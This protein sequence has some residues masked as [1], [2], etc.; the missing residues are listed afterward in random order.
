MK[1][2]FV[3]TIAIFVL[4]SFTIQN[5]SFAQDSTFAFKLNGHKYNQQEDLM[6]RA[7]EEWFLVAMD[8]LD[9]PGLIDSMAAANDLIINELNE[10]ELVDVFYEIDESETYDFLSNITLDTLYISATGLGCEFEVDIIGAGFVIGGVSTYVNGEFKI[11]LGE[12]VILDP[13]ISVVGTGHI[14]CPVL[15]DTFK[16]AIGSEIDSLLLGLASMY[17]SESFDN[18]LTF[19]NPIQ[20]LGIEDSVLIE[21]AL[22]SFPMN[23]DMY[24]EKDDD[25]EIVQL[26]IEIN[27]LLGTTSNPSAFIGIEPSEIPGSQLKTGGFSFLYWVL[28]NSFLWHDWT[29]SQRV[30]AAFGIMDDVDI[31]GYRLELRWSDLQ[32]LAYLGYELDPADITPDKI[33]SILTESEHWDTTAF[34]AIQEYLNNGITRELGPFMAVG[35]GHQDRM[36][37]DGSGLG[38]APATEEWEAAEGYT[39]VSASEYLYNLKIYAHATVRKFADEIEVWQ[40]EN[41]LNAAGFAAAVPELWRKGDLWLD[42]EFR[43]QVWAVLVDAV[44]TEDPDPTTMII[45]DLH[46]LGFMQGLEVWVEDM[47]IVGINYYPNLVASLP[48]MGFTVGEYVWAV[49]RA[50]NGLGHEEKPVWLTET[51]YP[52]IEIAD[53]PDNINLADD[54]V[55]FSENRQNEYVETALK[56]AVDNGVSGFFYYSL[57]TQEDR[58]GGITIPMRF[59]GMVRRD[60]D[61]YKPALQTFA[62]LYE[63]LLIIDPTAINDEILIFPEKASLHQNY[64][65]PF[66][67]KTVISYQL[68][69]SSSVRLHLF[70]IQGQLVETIYSG[71]Q[72]AGNHKIEWNAGHL[73]S[74]VYFYRLKAGNFTDIKKMILLK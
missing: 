73:A 9:L 61:V 20:A 36:P 52:G 51:G 27:F 64:P 65:N 46:M 34:L 67:P 14:L 44:R 37:V 11:N 35:V 16:S 69:V 45:H 40:I 19:L 74:G 6:I 38:I 13:E 5:Q 70:N 24:T 72:E 42:A 30:D 23:M 25:Q 21:Q 66:N 4:V 43:N 48:V 28:Q 59:S 12:P 47:D 2:L 18:L 41:E 57:V 53:P 50:L 31:N 56:S 71:R 17:E 26:I 15:A 39:G 55:Y 8:S 7:T 62:D 54:G 68:P 1:H 29:E 3:L 32:S 60:T 10:P 33:D 63:Q 49:R 58:P 22:E